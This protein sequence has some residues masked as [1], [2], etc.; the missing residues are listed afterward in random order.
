MWSDDIAVWRVGARGGNDK[1]RALRV[2]DW[3]ISAT[4]QR[5]YELL[6]PSRVRRRVRQG[7][8]PA[9]RAACDRP[10]RPCGFAL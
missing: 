6:D 3:F 7:L 2:T 8:R 4:T 5:R 10:S 9:A 1:A